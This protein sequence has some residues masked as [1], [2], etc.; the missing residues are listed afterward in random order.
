VIG[1]VARL[2]AGSDFLTQC[3]AR[4]WRG[5]DERGSPLIEL[6]LRQRQPGQ[7]EGQLPKI[8][9]CPARVPAADG[10]KGVRGRRQSC[11]GG[12][13]AGEVTKTMVEQVIFGI[14]G[15]LSADVLR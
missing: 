13:T 10:P 4:P 7:L 1:R 11:E 5:R 6:D 15:R 2:E 8:A 12:T 14:P 3:A 9:E